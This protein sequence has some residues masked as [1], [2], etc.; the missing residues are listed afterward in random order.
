MAIRFKGSLKSWNDERGFG[1]IETEQGG[2]EIFV[3]IKA[4]SN[5]QTR[6]AIG[7]PLSFEV[8][9]GPNKKKRAKHV[10]IT[11]P[12]RAAPIRRNDSPAHW[13]TATLFSIPAF[14]V[15]FAVLAFLWRIPF[16][17][18]V[19]YLTVSLVTFIAYALDKLAAQ[20]NRWRTSESTLHFLAIAGGWPGALLA[21]QY[22]R[23][24]SA[25]REF[26]AVFWATV[27]INVTAFVFVCSPVGKAFFNL[28]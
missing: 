24:K 22:L 8:E 23:H 15:L 14:V 6:P 1:F 27:V 12:A 11:R 17:Y 10:E 3:H 21:Q 9:L 5:L 2:E 25:K 20:S 16:T 18:A 28:S 4:F 7:L 13:G 19:V 26:R